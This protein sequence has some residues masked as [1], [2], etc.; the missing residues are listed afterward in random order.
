MRFDPKCVIPLLLSLLCLLGG[1]TRLEAR[2]ACQAD[3]L[4]APSDDPCSIAEDHEI[5]EGCTFDFGTRDVVL[6]ENRTLT[7]SGCTLPV[8]F[9]GGGF[10]TEGGSRIDGGRAGT[11]CGA[12]ILF[13]LSGDFDHAGEIDVSGGERPGSID[14]RTSAAI[15]ATGSWFAHTTGTTGD[16]GAI[17]L[18]AQGDIRLSN[19]RVVYL[20]GSTEGRGGRFSLATPGAVTLDQSIRAA[21]GNGG[22][23]TISISAGRTLLIGATRR[24]DLDAVGS[25][26][27]NGGEITLSAGETV[28][29]TTGLSRI[30]LKGGNSTEGSGNGGNLTIES[31]GLLQIGAA[32]KLDGGTSGGQ[33]GTI[34]IDAGG[35]VAILNYIDA[36]G[37]GLDGLGGS[38]FL[39]AHG[40]VTIDGKIDLS[41]HGSPPEQE[42]PAPGKNSGSGGNLFIS[43]TGALTLEARVDAS[44]SYGGGVLDLEIED[45]VSIYAEL[46]GQGGSTIPQKTEDGGRI[47][48]TSRSG[49]VLIAAPVTATPEVAEGARGSIELSGCEVEVTESGYLIRPEAEGHNT[50]VANDRVTIAGTMQAGSGNT[51]RYR[52]TPPVITGTITPPPELIED[53]TLCP[54]TA[55]DRDGDGV[56][57]PCDNCPDV[58]NPDQ[59]DCDGDGAGDP[60]DPQGDGDA[61]ADG[62]CNATDNCPDVA[63]PDQADG[64]SDGFG[65]LCDCNDENPRIH[66]GTPELC[67]DGIDNDCNGQTDSDDEPCTTNPCF[68]MFLPSGRVPSPIF[69][70]T[71]LAFPFLL[72]SLLRRLGR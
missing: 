48:I 72:L 61:D 28:T 56:G 50:I 31:G 38:L 40:D 5:G 12:R 69:P 8:T 30:L 33:G 25:G 63:N 2:Q 20:Q 65:A 51:I 10:R 54:C 6:L 16:G 62:V 68:E 29:L 66:P 46:N 42:A 41:T 45:D 49:R 9:R 37:G 60:C 35:P 39:S 19:D 24:V 13:D 26:R 36:P 1:R 15:H 18:S 11:A 70:L 27:G 3:D 17:T 23:G 44:G 67:H 55:P 52:E 47:S 43:S 58:A 4:C 7:I 71:L 32:M 53:P 64:D 21:G 22:G 34:S 59:A 57:D 14:V